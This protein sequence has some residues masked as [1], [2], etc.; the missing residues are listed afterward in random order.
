[1]ENKI[2]KRRRYIVRRHFQLKYVGL[3][4]SVVII[5]ALVSGYTIYYNSW[6]L[7][8]DNLANVYPQG[9]LVQIFRSVNIRFMINLIFVSMFC[10]GIGILASHRI[11]GP[12]YR[13][14]KFLEHAAKGDY[15]QRL[16]LRKG[17]EFKELAESINKL[18]DKIESDKK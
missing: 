10:I 16:R 6:T 7:L 12:V 5:S 15:S 8:G 17:D 13:M 3:I 2:Y 11:A 18:M 4:L 1:M 14:L 9:R